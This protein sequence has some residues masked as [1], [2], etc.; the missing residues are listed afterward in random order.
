[1]ASLTGDESWMHVYQTVGEWVAAWQADQEPEPERRVSLTQLLTWASGAAAVVDAATKVPGMRETL[2]KGLTAL[3][4]RIA[5]RAQPQAPP[6][7][8]G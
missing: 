7:P 1:M 8:E 6:P 5:Q 3:R 2:S 4:E